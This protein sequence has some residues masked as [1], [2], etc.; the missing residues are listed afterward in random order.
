MSN[1]FSSRAALPRRA[2]NLVLLAS[3]AA[4]AP[5]LGGCGMELQIGDGSSGGG[6][7]G[8]GGSLPGTTAATGMGGFPPATTAATGMGGG[9][10]AATGMGGWTTTA[11]GMGGGASA[12]TGMGGWTTTATGMGGRDDFPPEHCLNTVDTNQGLEPPPEEACPDIG[13]ALKAAHD[14]GLQGAE[15]EV[16]PLAG[17]WVTGSGPARIELVL[18]ASGQGTLLFGE[19]TDLPPISA[20]HDPYLTT[21]EANDANDIMGLLYVKRYPGFKYSVVA[22][23]GRGSEMSFHIWVMQVWDGWCAT[24]TPVFSPHARHC[25]A[26]MYDD[27]LYSFVSSSSSCEEP[28]GCY[29]G[30]SLEE[31]TRVDCGRVELCVMPYYNA[32]SCTADECFANLAPEGGQLTSYPYAV[33]ID[34]VDTTI[35][36]LKS[37]SELEDKTTYYLVKQP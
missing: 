21:R 33:T 37:L 4:T 25:Y 32:C 34:P 3:L 13:A 12:A 31:A 2:A 16:A 7:P 28:G 18:D 26:C 17:T 36:R 5:L 9:G 30:R 22:E 15:L 29:A 20:P 19:P 6:D 10:T 11:T 14:A 8:A 35:L 1:R 24:Q 27:G 23:S